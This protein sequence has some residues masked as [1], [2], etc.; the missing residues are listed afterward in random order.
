[1]TASKQHIE[2]ECRKVF[3]AIP[4]IRS[5]TKDGKAEIIAALLRNCRSNEHATQ[6]LREFG[7]GVHDW[8]NP[9][10]ELVEIAKRTT[11]QEQPPDGCDKCYEYT[12]EQT[13]KSVWAAHIEVV[14]NGYF[15]AVRCECP[16]GK[17]LEAKDAER[18]KEQRK[19]TPMESAGQQKGVA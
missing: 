15:C 5:L 6:V 12:N 14:R 18:R 1:M 11:P 13:G 9:I 16:R 7:E 17:W 4:L 3:G 8:H 19:V 10:A 2:S